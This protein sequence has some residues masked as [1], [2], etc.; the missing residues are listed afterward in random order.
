MRTPFNTTQRQS[1]S[2]RPAA[3]DTRLRS[4]TG[5]CLMAMPCEYRVVVEGE[6]GP[7]FEAAFRPMRL[8]VGDGTTAIIGLVRDQ[9]ELR[10]LLDAVSARGLSLISV[11]PAA[12]GGDLDV[13][14]ATR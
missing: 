2:P 11:V 3:R 9:A 1:A 5:D 4:W 8:E 14:V 7:R 13:P 12:G 10:G 6:L